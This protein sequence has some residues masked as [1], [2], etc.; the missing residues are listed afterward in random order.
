LYK[1]QRAPAKQ[2]LL[3]Q[4][5]A[6]Y[7]YKP[8]EEEREAVISKG[9]FDYPFFLVRVKKKYQ[10]EATG[11]NM[12][13]I[14][15]WQLDTV[16]FHQGQPYLRRHDNETVNFIESAWGSTD[17]DKDGTRISALPSRS[18]LDKR[19]IMR[20]GVTKLGSKMYPAKVKATYAKIIEYR[21]KMWRG[22]AEFDV[23]PEDAFCD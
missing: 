4:K 16:G 8:S 12:V 11:E 7:L 14:Q 10:D 5:D 21:L 9:G 13:R 20:V 15:R 3:F 22:G 1:V 19:F 2:S 23:A 17:A 18:V 6:I